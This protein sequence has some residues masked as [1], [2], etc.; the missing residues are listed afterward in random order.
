MPEAMMVSENNYGLAEGAIQPGPWLSAMTLADVLARP[1]IVT[2]AFEEPASAFQTIAIRKRG[3]DWVV[4]VPGGHSMSPVFLMSVEAIA[5][6]LS[7]PPGWNSY[8]AR[9]IDPRNAVRAIR[10]LGDVLDRES[11]PPAVVPRVQGGIQ[12]EW[13]TASVDIE[14]YIDTPERI[15]WFAED[16]EAGEGFDGPL[17]G[18]EAQLKAWVKRAS[19]R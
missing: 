2:A 12:L 1:S 14:L 13:H 17:A 10:L 5:D 19:G 18:N 15:S 8:S 16:V 6:L 9:A 11:S 3:T 4:E 7:L